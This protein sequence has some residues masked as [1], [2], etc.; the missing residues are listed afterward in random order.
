MNIKVNNTGSVKKTSSAAGSSKANKAQSASFNSALE[1]ALEADG[2]SN[3]QA[4]TSVEGVSNFLFET[5]GN[6]VPTES[7]KRGYYMLD[8]LEELEQD[9]LSGSETKVASKLE[10]ALAVEAV[11][12]DN[13]PKVVLD[14][15]EEIDLRAKIELEKLKI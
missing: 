2:V 12:K 9:I 13:L 5:A 3:V 4:T 15:M 1:Q 7:K 14:L 8:L 10:E 11:D 6:N